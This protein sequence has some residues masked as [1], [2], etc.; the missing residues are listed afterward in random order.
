MSQVPPWT[1]FEPPPLPNSPATLE[2]SVACRGCGYQLRGSLIDGNCSEC[3]KS[4]E[5]SLRGD[6]L[7]YAEAEYLRTLIRGTIIIEASLVVM[8]LGTLMVMLLS[9]MPV[10]AQLLP[11]V[12]QLGAIVGALSQFSNI[13]NSLNM[14]A[15]TLVWTIGWWMLSRPDPSVR[16]NDRGDRP[17][18]VLRVTLIISCVASLVIGGLSLFFPGMA[19]GWGTTRTGGGAGGAGVVPGLGLGTTIGATVLSFVAWIIQFFASMMYIRW[20]AQRIPSADIYVRAKLY[21]WVLPLIYL[22]VCGIGQI[23]VFIIYFVFMDQIRAALQRVLPAIARA[24]ALGPTVGPASNQ[25]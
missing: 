18:R 1:S 25:G 12:G 11:N 3:G 24:T 21:M 23:I 15:G 14:F 5:A 20:L 4:V 9:F 8:V 22:L 16:M 10:I 13:G 2:I 7:V 6:L 17:R 19:M